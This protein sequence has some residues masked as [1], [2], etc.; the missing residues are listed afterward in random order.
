MFIVYE[1]C[2]V[3]RSPE[4]DLETSGLFGCRWFIWEMILESTDGKRK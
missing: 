1:E 3:L 4:G 2:L